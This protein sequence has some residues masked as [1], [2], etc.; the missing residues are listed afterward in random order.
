MSLIK[1]TVTPLLPLLPSALVRKIAM[2]YVAGVTVEEAVATVL[3]LNKA[4]FC[5]TLDILGEYTDSIEAAKQI[6][7]AYLE[8][9]DTIRDEALDC[10]IS[11]KLTHLGLGF[12]DGLAEG[13]LSTVVRK[14]RETGNFLRI[15]M[16]N[17]PYTNE[18]LHLYRKCLAHH[19]RI[20]AVLQAYLYRSMGDLT[21]LTGDK[22]NIRICKGIYH[23]SEKI[24]THDR[25]EIRHNF[26]QL[27][28]KGLESGAYVAIATHDKLIID[29]LETWI[30]NRRISRDLYEFQVLYGVPMGGRL[31]QLL[32]GG[33]KVRIYVPFGEEWLSYATRRLE[34]NPHLAG[35]ILKNLFAR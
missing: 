32:E 19:A 3:R 17:S 9:Y 5:A 27:V 1:R 18:T 31:E 30:A 15:D 25:E 21:Q 24:A 34:E 35:Y 33:H 4:G 2:R 29:S 7:N 14:A 16:E 10:N 20:G 22:L 11:L 8:L 12:D 28:H 6:T 23:E 26:I 13:N